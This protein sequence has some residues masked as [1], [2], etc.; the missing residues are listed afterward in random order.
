MGFARIPEAKGI[1]ANS[2]SAP[3]KAFDQEGAS[4]SV[5]SLNLLT[6]CNC[7]TARWCG[8]QQEVN[9]QSVG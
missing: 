2:T 4:P 7:V 5:E 8:K 3:V 6:K 9:G 1:L